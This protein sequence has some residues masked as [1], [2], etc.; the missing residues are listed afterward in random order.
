[1]KH[2]AH[3]I[4]A[5]LTI[6]CM[7]LTGCEGQA[8]KPVVNSVT[9]VTKAETKVSYDLTKMSSTMV[10]AQVLDMLQNPSDYIGKVIKM[11]GI[12]VVYQNYDATMFYPACQIQ[13]AT[14]CCA[15]GIEFLMPDRGNPTVGNEI[16]VMGTF[17][18][19]LED[20]DVY[21]RLVDTTVQY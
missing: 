11:K 16:T 9:E 15:S 20:S 14:A 19:Y 6:S 1:M 17:E 2:F 5:I 10:Y 4:F 13:D 8:P 12:F 18:S 21:Y 7:V 3:L